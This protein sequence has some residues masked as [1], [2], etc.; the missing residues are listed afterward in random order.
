MRGRRHAPLTAEQKALASDPRH[1]DLASRIARRFA[2]SFPALAEEF[3]SEA[4]LALCNAARTFEP[5]RRISFFTHAGNRIYGSMLDVCRN[6]RLMGYRRRH[7]GRA[8]GEAPHVGS[9]DAIQAE[10]EIGRTF[11]FHDALASDDEPIGWEAE[12]MD[13]L[14][15]LTRKLPVKHRTVLRLLYGHAEV[16]TMKGTG[17]AIGLSESQVSQIHTEAIQMLRS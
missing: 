4:F 8:V 17:R 9:L 11:S 7:R 14:K 13:E 5:V 12:S 6:S 16:A 10:S 2:W 15:G 3:R 1:L